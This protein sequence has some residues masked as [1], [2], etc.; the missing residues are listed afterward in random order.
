M[1][2]RLRISSYLETVGAESAAAPVGDHGELAG[3]HELFED[4]LD[5]AAAQAGFPLQRGLVD[6][7]LAVLIG[8]AGDDEED[9]AMGAP[10]A[11]V[12]ED[13]IDMV[14]AQGRHPA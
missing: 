4:L 7:P 1:R 14:K 10:Q 3:C 13:G 12:V 6:A 2:I 5:P 8:I 11:R 9:E